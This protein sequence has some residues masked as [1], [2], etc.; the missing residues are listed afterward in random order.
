VHAHQVRSKPRWPYEP[1]SA[2]SRWRRG[3]V[4][5]N[6]C[7]CTGC[8]LAAALAYVRKPAAARMCA[9]APGD[10]QTVPLCIVVEKEQRAGTLLLHARTGDAQA[11]LGCIAA[12]ERRCTAT[13]ACDPGHHSHTGNQHLGLPCVPSRDMDAWRHRDIKQLRMCVHA[14]LTTCEPC[15][16]ASSWRKSS[17]H[18]CSCATRTGRHAGSTQPLACVHAHLA[19]NRPRSAYE[20]DSASLWWRTPGAS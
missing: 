2:S 8:A 1:D 4:Q 15:S 20:P 7:M 19:T 12:E 9:G 16:D 3:S 13:P 10:M 6:P 5:L 18:N 17:I 11:M 14:H